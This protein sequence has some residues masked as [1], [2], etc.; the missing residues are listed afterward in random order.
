MTIS[1]WFDVTEHDHVR[2]NPE[3]PNT[4]IEYGDFE[5]PYCAAAF[6]VLRELVDES[7]GAVRL[8]FRHFPVPDVHPH[9]L[10]AALAAEAAGSVGQFWEMHDLLFERQ[11]R[12]TGR[13]LRAYAIELGIDPDLVAGERAQQFGDAVEQSF[14]SGVDLDVPGTPTL[15]VNT[16]LYRGRMDVTNLRAA[17]PGTAAPRGSVR[18][19]QPWARRKRR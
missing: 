14:G 8:I 10:T 17:M 19:F 9:A 11:S 5:C 16:D 13:D 7:D 1:P 12:L 6:P 18:R 15:F 2:G 4:V 3:A